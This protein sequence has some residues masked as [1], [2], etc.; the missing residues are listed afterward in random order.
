I[1]SATDRTLLTSTLN[2][3]TA[4]ARGFNKPPYVGFPATLTVAQSLRPYPQ[5]GTIPIHYAP[6]GN[7][8]YDGL[9]T[10]LTKRYSHGL[11]LT[12]AFTWSKSQT[13]GAES[14]TGGGIINDVFN[15][16]TRRPSPSAT[17]RASS[18]SPSPT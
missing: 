18:W 10:K 16:A 11:V 12:G 1:N 13:L 7:T 14:A 5:F 8:W 15:R 3:S 17:S 4:A 2:S 9:Q 6:L